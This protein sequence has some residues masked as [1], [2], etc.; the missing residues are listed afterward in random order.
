MG[1]GVNVGLKKL[2]GVL[3]LA[4]MIGS[5]TPLQASDVYSVYGRCV[6]TSEGVV[7]RGHVEAGSRH[8]LRWNFWFRTLPEEEW[9]WDAWG[10]HERVDI[11]RD[12]RVLWRFRSDPRRTEGRAYKL[13]ITELQGAP[14]FIAHYNDS[15]TNPNCVRRTG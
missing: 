2:V 7:L 8:P 4:V 11:S 10:T 6:L 9:T 5:P 3:V 1:R 12:G 13:V 14:H 15:K